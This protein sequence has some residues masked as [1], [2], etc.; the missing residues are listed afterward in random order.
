MYQTINSRQAR[1]NFSQM[2]DLAMQDRRIVIT[3]FNRPA[4]VVTGFD[5]FNPQESMNKKDWKK[6]FKLVENLREKTKKL[7]Q[8]K[9]NQLVEEVLQESN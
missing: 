3:R 4:V 6:G 1:N 8:Q 5:D 2:L 9:I 7:P